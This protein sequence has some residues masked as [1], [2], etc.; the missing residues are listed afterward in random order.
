MA[1]RAFPRFPTWKTYQSLKSD[2]DYPEF[3]I[4]GERTDT[5][6]ALLILIEHASLNRSGFDYRK[7]L[8]TLSRRGEKSFIV[9]SNS[10]ERFILIINLGPREESERYCLI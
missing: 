2:E 8:F 7:L 10:V 5:F 3:S 6:C 1:I 4:N 9:L